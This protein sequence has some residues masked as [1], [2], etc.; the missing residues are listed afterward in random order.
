M[1]ATRNSALVAQLRS[2]TVVPVLTIDDA[3]AAIPL[4]RALAAGGLGVI[5][6]T[7]R[8]P[9]ALDAIRRITAEV[10]EAAVGAGTVLT[11]SDGEAA[12]AAGS[13]FLV[14]PGATPRLLDAAETWPVP[15]LPGCAT[16]S[17][18]MALL[19]RGYRVA[20]LFPAEQAGGVKLLQALAAPLPALSFCP[21]GGIGPA[22]A[23]DYLAL[24]NVVCVG[25]SWV[26]PKEAVA[27]GDWQTI[28]RLAAAA[29]AMRRQ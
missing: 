29:L 16:A 23:A 6:V 19:D 12:I 26:A 3:A 9:A 18:A 8:T 25:G 11:T 27:T 20:K 28:T 15:L 1:T 17:E 22:N 21:T 10:P 4:A 13:R 2:A 5:E 24:P 7:L 14:S